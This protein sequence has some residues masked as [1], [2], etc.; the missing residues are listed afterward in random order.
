MS[1]TTR[2]HPLAAV[3]APMLALM[4][5]VAPAQAQEED[6]AQLLDDFVHYAQ[7][8]R[9]DLAVA[10]AQSLIETGITNQELAVL[11]DSG[12]SNDIERFN[13]AVQWALRVPELEGV[14]REL[15]ER[16]ELGRLELA[17]DGDRINQAIQMLVGTKREQLL[18][19]KRLKAAGEYAVP[20]LLLVI[21]DGGDSKLPTPSPTR[22]KLECKRMIREI[23]LP[24]VVPLCVALKRVDPTSQRVVCELLGDMGYKHAA[25]FLRDFQTDPA[26]PDGLRD[27]AAAALFAIDVNDPDVSRLYAQLA[28]DYYDSHESLI[29]YPF[30]DLNNVWSYDDFVGL[31]PTP[32]STEIFSEIMA[33]K[34]SARSVE[35]DP[36]NREALALF[37]AANLRRENDLPDGAEDPIFGERPYSPAFFATVFGT[38]VAQDVLALALDTHDTPLVRDAIAA[39]A[40]TTGGSNLFGSSDRNPLLEA[41]S[42]PD[43]RVQ[44]EAALTLARALPD[45]PFEGSYRVVPILAS[46]VRIGGQS[47]ALV[48]SDDEE[49]RRQAVIDTE[50]VG[51]R[52]VGAEEDV[53]SLRGAID[54]ATGV[55]LVVVRMRTAEAAMQAVQD[56]ALATKTTAAPVLVLASGVDRPGLM[57]EFRANPRVKVANVIVAEGGLE[58]NIDE[59]LERA[60][61]GRMTEAEAEAYAFEALDA[62][63]GI[64]I[65]CTNAFDLLD[66]ES[67]LLDALDARE[68][69]A[70]LLVAGIVARIDTDRAQRRLFD[71]ALAASGGERID[72]LDRVAESVKRFGD[73]AEPRHIAGLVD[74]VA[75]TTGSTAEAAA[76]VH[77]A[78]NMSTMEAI[79]LI[80]Q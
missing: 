27:V 75:N 30:E 6:R 38:Q 26:T 68:G 35:I 71:V 63:K 34:M 78:L 45:D 80:N 43:R 23:G 59:L 49:N 28:R 77:G 29:P 55:D 2:V 62:L 14:A 37:V 22:L 33:M 76:R 19:I 8:A 56:L 12:D 42:Y 9:P 20:A 51:F 54:D 1:L 65:S 15:S 39:L 13:T 47:F 46:A 25:P 32:V 69:R 16:V 5:A 72:L 48:V 7:I 67:S 53:P 24:S 64:S 70:R 73:R 36:T 10:F 18:A 41:L 40:E 21:T 44:Y 66:A 11:V 31:E 79:G 4:L 74:L 3:I 61:G 57:I 58:A 52:V 60:A 50:R 17:R